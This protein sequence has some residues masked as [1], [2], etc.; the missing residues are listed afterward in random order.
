MKESHISLEMTYG[1]WGDKSSWV[2]DWSRHGSSIVLV[3]KPLGKKTTELT[4]VS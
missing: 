3:G 4:M 2:L 1:Q